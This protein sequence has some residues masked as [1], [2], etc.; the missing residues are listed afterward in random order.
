M[1][2]LMEWNS[3]SHDPKTVTTKDNSILLPRVGCHFRAVDLLLVT[4]LIIKILISNVLNLLKTLNG[5]LSIGLHGKGETRILE[6]VNK[7]CRSKM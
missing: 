5:F 3:G 2:Q 1:P 6:K 7:G 4:E